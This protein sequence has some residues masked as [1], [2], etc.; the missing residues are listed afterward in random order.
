MFLPSHHSLLHSHATLAV[1]IIFFEIKDT[2]SAT[3]KTKVAGPPHTALS[4]VPLGRIVWLARQNQIPLHFIY[5]LLKGIYDFY[6]ENSLA[7]NIFIRILSRFFF[8]G[9]R[10]EREI[11]LG[12]ENQSICI[13]GCTLRTYCEETIRNCGYICGFLVVNASRARLRCVNIY[14]ETTT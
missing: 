3:F 2:S 10:C 6:K 8:V 9:V 5:Y 1:E 13:L 7:W 4:L 14:Q 12:K 11:G